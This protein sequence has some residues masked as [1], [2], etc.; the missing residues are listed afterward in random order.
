MWCTRPSGAANA[1]QRLDYTYDPVSG[2]IATE[3]LLTGTGTPLRQQAD[4]YYDGITVVRSAGGDLE[5]VVTYQDWDQV[6]GTFTDTNPDTCYFRYYTGATQGHELKRAVLASDYADA[7][8]LG[9]GDPA[10]ASY[11]TGDGQSD[12]I[13][14]YTTS[15]FTYD[16]KQRVTDEAVSD[17]TSAYQPTVTPSSYVVANQIQSDPYGPEQL[18]PGN[19]GDPARR[20]D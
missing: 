13:A 17:N 10:T 20:L 2:N 19:G 7:V 11:W 6:L 16:A 9:N 14:S 8:A 3:T 15:Y 4:F 5:K 1:Y 12:P 18:D